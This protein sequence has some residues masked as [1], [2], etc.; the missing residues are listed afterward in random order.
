MASRSSTA[1]LESARSGRTRFFIQFSG[2]GNSFLLELRR[3]HRQFPE[4]EDYFEAVFEAIDETLGYEG[5]RSS[6]MLPL[7]FDLRRWLRKE[8]VPSAEYLSACTV[9]LPATEL[10]QL[11]YY[12]VLIRRGL[13]PEPLEFVRG[14]TGHSQ[15]VLAAV[16]AALDLRGD[17]WYVGLKRHI[18]FLLM[19]GV[20]CQQ[21]VPVPQ[22][23]PK[24]VQ[25]STELDGEVP[26]PMA[27]ISGISQG[28]LQT[29]LDEFNERLPASRAL[30]ISLLNT[31][32]SMCISGHRKDV[33][34]FRV[35]MLERLEGAEAAWQYLDISA[36]FHSHLMPPGVERF[37]ED[38]QWMG[39]DYQGHHLRRPVY[40]THDGRNLQD[41]GSLG[42]HL[43]LLQSSMSLNW[44]KTLT[45]LIADPSITH[46]IDCGPGRVSGALTAEIL[47]DAG[48][49]ARV[50]ALASRSDMSEVIGTS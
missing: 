16:F 4:L 38:L 14:L 35:S 19:G 45:A 1:L 50:L 42:E 21:T 13:G 46:V 12:T 6:H 8:Q 20:R 3:L 40:S 47:R 39:Y 18:Q 17:E 25:R 30:T 24:I 48:H 43:F 31:R 22:L 34:E 11:A 7:G 27:T 37:R 9:S 10:T 32:S 23:D 44:P 41:L 36:P 49:A 33:F 28:S 2:Q 5:M 26:T 15:G 29:M